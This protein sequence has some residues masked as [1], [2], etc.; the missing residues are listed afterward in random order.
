MGKH[1]TDIDLF[2]IVVHRGDQSN[3]I[4]SNVKHREFTNSVGSWEGGAK[5]G[6]VREAALFHSSV[7][8][9]RAD[10]VSG[11]FSANSFR[12]FRVM[13][14]IKAGH[15][16]CSTGSKPTL[17]VEIIPDTQRV[18]AVFLAGVR[19]L[20]IISTGESPPPLAPAISAL[21]ADISQ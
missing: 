8:T 10:V 2:S 9:G 7:P 14:C 21:G 6:E 1:S 5:L 4:S 18:Q 3:L 20:L 19:L 17:D 16:G 11:N 15:S 12:R 13:T